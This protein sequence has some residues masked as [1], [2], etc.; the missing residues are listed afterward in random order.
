MS[1]DLQGSG[2]MVMAALGFFAVAI[3]GMVFSAIVIA[4]LHVMAVL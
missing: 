2:D 1:Y 3:V 4:A